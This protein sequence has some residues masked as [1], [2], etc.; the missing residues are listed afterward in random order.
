M[1]HPRFRALGLAV[2]AS[3]VLAQAIAAQQAERR[4][5]LVIGNS[6]YKTTP[7]AN[8]RRLSSGQALPAGAVRRHI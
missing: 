1:A 4:T 2:P 8:P 3:L 7:L 5:A 6:T